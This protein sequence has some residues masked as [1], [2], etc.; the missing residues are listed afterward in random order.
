MKY[1]VFKYY[2]GIAMLLCIGAVVVG[3]NPWQHIDWKLVAT[4][5]GSVISSVFFLQKQ[6]LEELKLFNELYTT[7]NSRYDAL[8]ESLNKIRRGDS[9]KNLVPG[10]L[11]TPYSYFNLCGE[12]YSYYKQGFLYPEVWKAWRN[13]MKIFYQVARIKQEWDKELSNDSYYG[14]KPSELQ[15]NR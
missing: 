11:D 14:L 2:F 13:G 4:F 10:E 6:R 15:E 7:F 9:E 8:N 12:E 5:I 3:I 1:F